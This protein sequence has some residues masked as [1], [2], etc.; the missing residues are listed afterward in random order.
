MSLVK[1]DNTIVSYNKLFCDELENRINKFINNMQN[2][3]NEESLRV[4]YIYKELSLKEY[5]EWIDELN[6]ELNN[7]DN[8]NDKLL[9]EKQLQY[10][11]RD[12]YRL[13]RFNDELEQKRKDLIEKFSKPIDTA[14]NIITKEINVYHQ[15]MLNEMF[16]EFVDKVK[17]MCI[18][19]KNYEGTIRNIYI[20]RTS[21]KVVNIFNSLT[22][23]LINGFTNLIRNIGSNEMFA[24]DVSKYDM[25]IKLRKNII[26]VCYK[27][28]NGIIIN[29]I[30]EKINQYPS[31]KMSSSSL[32][33]TYSRSLLSNINNFIVREL[34]NKIEDEL[35]YGFNKISNN[36]LVNNN[37]I[38]KTESVNNKQIII[39]EPKEQSSLA[40]R[41][42][43][44]G[45]AFD[46]EVVSANRRFDVHEMD[47]N[48]A[49][50]SKIISLD[51]F[52]ND[53]PTNPINIT[54]L[55]KQYN[56]YFD[57]NISTRGVGMILSKTDKLNKS[58][59][60]ECG[61]KVIYYT[62]FA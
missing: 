36:E 21:Q 42:D 16:E 37:N 56:E 53:L 35:R 58:I 8:E 19:D 48:N 59:C 30:C 20:D 29:S 34:S 28:Y 61:K 40:L 14:I 49:T 18:E 13:I 50:Q 33:K 26:D 38:D 46:K 5:D 41:L 62:K 24:Y 47:D 6:N 22:Q 32:V 17:S 15:N 44:S 31:N 39:E 7:T 2:E 45:V 52:I 51:D 12:K 43:D 57:K 55:T 23:R 9:L 1:C 3:H 11:N 60:W 27:I 4:C 54:T 25:L 10:I